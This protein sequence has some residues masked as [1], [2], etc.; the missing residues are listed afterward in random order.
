MEG[1]SPHEVLQASLVERNHVPHRSHPQEPAVVRS[2]FR[3]QQGQ[4]EAPLGQG[5]QPPQIELVAALDVPR[6]RDRRDGIEALRQ[7][8][9]GPRIH[10]GRRLGDR[11][12]LGSA[13]M[14][15]R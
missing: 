8:T 5:L 3:L 1:G 14:T 2:A 12:R 11:I 15:F 10:S 7:R 6:P 4:S 9:H 13:E